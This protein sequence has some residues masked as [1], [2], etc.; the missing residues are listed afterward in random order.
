MRHPSCHPDRKYFAKSLCVVCYQRQNTANWRARNPKRA[1]E[2]Q[3]EWRRSH[4]D[5]VKLYNEKNKDIIKFS[6]L[7][8]SIGVGK[9]EYE[10]MWSQ[11]KGKCAICGNLM[12]P[13]YIDHCHETMKVRGL[14]CLNCNT[15]IGQLHHDLGI[16][17]S[18]IKYLGVTNK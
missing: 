8:R 5:R 9:E 6:K 1:N 10:F 18:A 15:G 12:Q 2:I 17:Q 14:L 4:P 7:K 3:N 13:A 16:L 11:Q